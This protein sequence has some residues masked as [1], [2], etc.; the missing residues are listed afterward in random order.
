MSF[1]VVA[2]RISR[3]SSVSSG[4]SGRSTC[5]LQV[6]QEAA[7]RTKLRALTDLA[8]AR[9]RTA[10][11]LTTRPK[12]CAILFLHKIVIFFKDKRNSFWAFV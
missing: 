9:P 10:A 11:I 8:R 6:L 12:V 1:L 2:S 5:F 3:R 4:T 7:R